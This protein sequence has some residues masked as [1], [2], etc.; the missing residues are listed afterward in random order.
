MRDMQGF[1]ELA[2]CGLVS[3]IYHSFRYRFKNTFRGFQQFCHL[4][5]FILTRT[6]I[7]RNYFSVRAVCR[8]FITFSYIS[9]LLFNT[10]TI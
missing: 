3:K 2:N 10:D 6:E 9:R 4:I 1:I 5:I 8:N 7:S